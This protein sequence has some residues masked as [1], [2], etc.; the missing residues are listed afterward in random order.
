MQ[1]KKIL[2]FAET[3]RDGNARV[4]SSRM[5]VVSEIEFVQII[6]FPMPARGLMQSQIPP[7]SSLM[8]AV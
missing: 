6:M 3:K 1:T 4:S 8:R 7:L 2:T 5:Y